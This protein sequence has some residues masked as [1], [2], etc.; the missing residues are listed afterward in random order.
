MLE[1]I[2]ALIEIKFGERGLKLLPEIAHCDAVRLRQIK[3]VI[4][5]SQEFQDVEKAV[6][7]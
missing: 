3:E 2:E 6:W 4:K 5:A 7:H 1:G